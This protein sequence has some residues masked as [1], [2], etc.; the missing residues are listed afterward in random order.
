MAALPDKFPQG[1]LFHFPGG[2]LQVTARLSFYFLSALF[3]IFAGGC[4]S[5]PG[6]KPSLAA[7]E[8]SATTL[9]DWGVEIIALRLSARDR[10]LDFRFRVL[11]PE[12]SRPLFHRKTH[13]L[14]RHEKTGKE[15][16]VHSPA[17]L[18]PLR[19]SYLP[20]AGRVY[21]II[22]SNPGRLVERGDE[23]TLVIGDFQAGGLIVE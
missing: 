23:T 5:T 18:G 19:S 16:R 15:L 4:A 3:L 20:Q 14:L 10:M 21:F 6:E 9:D 7:V 22:F 1:G 8:E 17:K 12:K 11:D 2:R 13:P